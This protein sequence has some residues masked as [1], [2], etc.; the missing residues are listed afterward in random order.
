MIP[1]DNE[2]FIMLRKRVHELEKE[3]D[4]HKQVLSDL[5]R[6]NM[7]LLRSSKMWHAKYEDLLDQ[8]EPQLD[9]YATPTKHK[10]SNGFMFQN[11]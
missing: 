3:I 8:S 9:L 5:Q 7:R 6:E 2:T 4:D 1:D 11:C 10:L